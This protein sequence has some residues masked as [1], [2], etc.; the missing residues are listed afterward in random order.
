MRRLIALYP[1][2]WRDRYAAEFEDLLTDRPMSLRDRFDI[3][4]GAIDAWIHPQ[5]RARRIARAPTAPSGGR[6]LGAALAVVGGG[7][8]I[9][10]GVGM[11]GTRVD[12]SLTYKQVD[13]PFLAMILGMLVVSIVAIVRSAS[14][15]HGAGPATAASVIMLAGALGTATPWPFLVIG[16]FGFTGAATVFGLILAAR[17]RQPV[18]ALVAIASLLMTGI[19]TEDE[20]ALLTIPVAA[21]WILLG[22]A[23]LRPAASSIA[24]PTTEQSG[25]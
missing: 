14:M 12:P 1:R 4:R 25:P 16:L 15:S 3:A 13:V 19:N 6:L 2:A 20:R 23:D 8:L 17:D 24:V 18:G 9:L 22:I 11:V 10:A 21:A 7:L 5:V